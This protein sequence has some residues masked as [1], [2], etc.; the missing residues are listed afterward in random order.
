MT[1]AE[2]VLFVASCP[3]VV[4]GDGTAVSA[5]AVVTEVVDTQE[6]YPDAS[7]VQVS[8][9]WQQVIEFAPEIIPPQQVV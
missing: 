3:V 4:P 5:P 6:G 1:L 2:E 8:K 7:K 9:F